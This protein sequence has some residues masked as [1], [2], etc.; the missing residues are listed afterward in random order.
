MKLYRENDVIIEAVETAGSFI[1]RLAGLLGKKNVPPDYGLYF[2]GCNSIHTF[3]MQFAIDVIMLSKSG[4]VESAVSGLVPWRAAFCM[5]AAG[6]IETAAGT[7][8][9]FGIKKGDILTLRNA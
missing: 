7:I 6:T 5:K 4:R 3:F 8:A 9:R 1:K 2:P